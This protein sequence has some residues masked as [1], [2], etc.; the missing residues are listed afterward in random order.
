MSWACSSV[1][2]SSSRSSWIDPDI[3]ASGFRISCAIPAAISP[4]AARRCC[5]RASRS[6]RLTVVTSWNVKRYPA[7]PS[8]KAIVAA[9]APRSI[10]RPSRR[11]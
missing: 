11:W 9:A 4:T 3:D 5:R 10:V 7:R 1:S 6:S 8:G 2:A